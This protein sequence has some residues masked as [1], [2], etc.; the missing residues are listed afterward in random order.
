VS[1]AIE[2]HGK[3]VP[4]RGLVGW[5]YL[6]P[7]ATV[8]KPRIVAAIST[9]QYVLIQI[10]IKGHCT[11]WCGGSYRRRLLLP[12]RSVPHPGRA[13]GSAKQDDIS[14]WVSGYPTASR[15]RC[16]WELLTPSLCDSIPDPGVSRSGARL[17]GA[18][19]HDYGFCIRIVCHSLAVEPPPG[20]LDSLSA[21]STTDPIDDDTALLFGRG[22]I[23]EGEVLEKLG[24]EPKALRSHEKAAAMFE[25]R[26][27]ANKAAMKSLCAVTYAKV[28]G[29][30]ARLGLLDRAHQT[31][32]KA[33]ALIP[34]RPPSEAPAVQDQY[35]LMDIYAGLGDLA[36]V[37]AGTGSLRGRAGAEACRCYQ[38]S[39][40]NWQQ[41]PLRGTV[42]PTGFR[43]IDA[44]KLATKLAGCRQTGP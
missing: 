26:P 33:L 35:V 29:A 31:Y 15:G 27:L 12:R 5:K 1:R 14:R 10:C 38:K 17:S 2:V 23:F 34:S 13:R 4:A 18:A 7:I 19:E 24:D 16:C 40:D 8:P 42:S 28:A 44:R 3:S 11:V 36:S 39:I 25:S 20:G 9:V 43:V 21:E 32:S 6:S 22:S 41:L 37:Q 30:L